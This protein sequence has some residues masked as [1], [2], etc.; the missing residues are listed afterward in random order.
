MG[1]PSMTGFL[2]QSIYDLTNMFWLARIGAAPVAAI[3]MCATYIWVL[4]F[5]NMVIG[6][7]S[8]ATISRRYGEG[9]KGRTEM[10][11]KSTFLLKFI[12]GSLLGVVG[13]LTLRFA[14]KFM[15]AAPDVHELAVD[16][17][18]IQFSTLGFAMTSYSVYTAL[19]S[20]SR[21]KAAFWMQAL[22]AA[23]N[24]MLDPLL[25]F[26]IGPFPEWGIMG[27][28]IATSI[29]SI[30]VVLGGCYALSRPGDIQ[31]HWFRKPRPTLEELWSIIRVGLPGGVNQLSFSLSTTVVIKLVA[32]FG[33]EVVAVYGM[34]TKALHFG[35][36]MVAGLGL[37]TGALIGQFLGGKQLDRAWLAGVLSTRLAGWIMLGYATLLF[38][39][40]PWIV[41][42]FFKEQPQLWSLGSHLLRIMAVSL[43]MIG[44]HIGAETAFEGAGQN[45]PPMILSIVHAWVMVIPFMWVLGRIFDFG[46]PGLMW[47]W[48]IAHVAGGLAAIWMLNRGT[49]LKH[50]L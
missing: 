20:T 15:G 34:A 39:F 47:G 31:V 11:I 45:T 8:V 37:G 40:A 14:L 33:T 19:R 32:V 10:S 38:A 23:V 7:G 6:V 9:D 44:I 27:A 24:A 2:V 49:W 21:P 28:G 16:Y 46:A 50:E 22:G 42:F 29:A 25:I 5:P 26:G 41:L 1:L 35:V 30:T 3:T 17:G 48:T 18:M 36:M 12:F 4:S 43:P 13:I